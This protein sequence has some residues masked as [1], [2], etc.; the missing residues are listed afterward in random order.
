MALKRPV[1]P[2]SPDPTPASAVAS[3]LLGSVVVLVVVL[4]AAFIAMRSVALD[5]ARRDTGERVVGLATLVEAAGLDDGLVRGDRGAI[6][7]IDRLV[8]RRVIGGSLVRVKIWSADGTI[9]YSDAEELIGER[10]ELGGDEEE[11]IA[12]GGREVEISDL[13]KPENRLERSEGR[14]MEAYT[15]VQAAGGTPMLFEIYQRFSSVTDDGYAPPQA[16]R[17]RNRR[18]ADPPRD[19]A[20]A[21]GLVA[22]ATPAARGGGAGLPDDLR[23]RRLQRRARAHRRRPARRRGAGPRRPG[24]RPRASHRHRRTRGPHRGRRRPARHLPPAP[25][26]RPR[27]AH[28]AR[29]DPPAQP[30][31]DRHRRRAP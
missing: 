18:R 29:G 6:A 31:D 13:S 14:L 2:G 23:R 20:G 8:A 24:I 9:L 4:I 16:A 28:P 21:A 7:R 5:E 22:R 26:E 10:Y 1:R 12:E 27:P 25:A 15:R 19:P 11:V 17:A 3:F 30:R